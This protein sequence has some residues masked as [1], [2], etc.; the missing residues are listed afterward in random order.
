[1]TVTPQREECT[2]TV[3]GRRLM[4]MELSRRQGKRGFPTGVGARPRRRTLSTDAWDR[5]GEEIAAAKTRFRLP[6]P[7]PVSSCDEAGRDG[8]WIHR[9]LAS[10]GSSIWWGTPRASK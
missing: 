1:M 4:S 3:G 6:A 2:A 10:L 9:Y 8:V 7:A 5:W